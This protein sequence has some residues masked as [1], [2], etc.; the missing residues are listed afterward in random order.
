MNKHKGGTTMKRVIAVL[1]ATLLLAPA[2][3]IAA[4]GGGVELISR[5][6]VEVMQQNEKGESVKKRIEAAKRN[7]APGDTVIYTIS[8]ANNG[9][10]PASDVAINNPVPEHM[11]YVDKSVEGIGTRIE[12]SIDKGKSYGQLGSLKIKNKAGR[13]RPARGDDITNLRWTIEKPLEPGSKGSV[14]FRAKV[15]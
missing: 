8:Y 12:F 7:V 13:E 3:L 1:L 14:S 6:E 2:V 4:P 9:N 15:K 11:L 5:A 10:K